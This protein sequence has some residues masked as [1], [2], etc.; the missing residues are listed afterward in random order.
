MKTDDCLS[1]DGLRGVAGA[2]PRKA[3]GEELLEVCLLRYS[4]I[5]GDDSG[6]ELVIYWQV[7]TRFKIVVRAYL[8]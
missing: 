1:V 3:T 5:Y 8:M 4:D 7:L 2:A 6:F